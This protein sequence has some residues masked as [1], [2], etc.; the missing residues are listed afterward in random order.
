MKVT[1]VTE[2]R[3]PHPL[4]QERLYLILAALFV[5]S[6][7][8]CNLI[9]QKFITIDLLLVQVTVSV[10]LLPYPVTFLVTDILSEIYGKRRANQVVVAG[11]I[12]SI[13]MLGI[14][15]TANI[16]PAIDGSPVNDDLFTR[17]FGLSQVAVFASMVAYLAAQF[18]DIRIFHFWKRLTNGKHLWLR[19]NGST[20]VSQLLDTLL[21]IGLLCYFE[22]LEWSMFGALV[23]DGF[24]YKV[25]FAAA[26]TPLFY[27]A[28][29]YLRNLFDLEIHEELSDGIHPG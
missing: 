17:V 25:I 19:N 5:T 27:A 1:F 2:K 7:V 4:L 15:W 29:H 9:F 6:L 28:A 22:V 14:V 20:V 11:L 18:I 12:A 10:G 8:T 23:R 16:V 3:H 24:L 21:V 26:D 13:F